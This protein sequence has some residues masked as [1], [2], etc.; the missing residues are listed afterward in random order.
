MHGE[1]EVQ[2]VDPRPTRE[3]TKTAIATIRSRNRNLEMT[4]PPPIARTSRTSRSNNNI[5]YLPF[6]KN[7]LS[8]QGIRPE[9]E[10]SQPWLRLDTV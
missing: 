2:T 5:P 7:L 9:L 8:L 3:N 10:T 6:A 4:I 1:A